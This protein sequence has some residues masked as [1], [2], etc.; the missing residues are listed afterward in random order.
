MFALNFPGD[1]KTD[2]EEFEKRINVVVK[3]L[4]SML[5]TASARHPTHIRLHMLS[6]K[7]WQLKSFVATP[8]ALSTCHVCLGV[9]S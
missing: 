5:N 4:Q 2:L 3:K 6:L 9:Q 8:L 1:N 7:K